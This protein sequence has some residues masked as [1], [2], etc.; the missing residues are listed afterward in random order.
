MLS[1]TQ[2]SQ[3][4]MF[5]YGLLS[6]TARVERRAEGFRHQQCLLRRPKTVPCPNQWWGPGTE[7]GELP[8]SSD[9]W[10]T[11]LPSTLLLAPYRNIQ[12]ADESPPR[13]LG[14]L[15]PTVVLTSSL[16]PPRCASGP[17]SL[18]AAG[19]AFTRLRG[20]G[21]F[22][23]PLKSSQY[24]EFLQ[25]FTIT[26]LVSPELLERAVSNAYPYFFWS[27][28]KKERDA[29]LSVTRMAQPL[30]LRQGITPLPTRAA[31]LC[32]L[33]IG[34]GG[35]I[36]LCMTCKRCFEM[37]VVPRTCTARRG[38]ADPEG[39]YV[40]WLCPTGATSKDLSVAGW[41]VGQSAR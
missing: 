8:S 27:N 5:R 9:K 1:Q 20:K 23:F 30:F 25:G 17:L 32:A 18:S 13:Q 10:C 29:H 35:L 33:R 37:R 3:F 14:Q 19:W 36:F 41:E 40:S 31:H 12:S 38:Q 4:S 7:E 28:C 6:S 26:L 34:K 22:S 39:G 11:K 24:F 21:F 15:G 16:C 2:A